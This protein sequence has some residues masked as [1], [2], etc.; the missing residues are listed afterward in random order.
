MDWSLYSVYFSRYFANSFLCLYTYAVILFIG[1]VLFKNKFTGESKNWLYVFNIII[2]YVSLFGLLYWIGELLIT[3]YGQNPYELHAFYTA[4]PAL[5]VW[6]IYYFLLFPSLMGLLFFNRKL[7]LR[8]WF[9]VFYVVVLNS[10][11]IWNWIQRFNNDYLPSEWSVITETFWEK[12]AK[13]ISV[14]VVII[15][16]YCLLYKRNKLP[17]SSI[18]FKNHVQSV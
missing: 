17:H 12:S 3:W 9:I 11:I 16:T 8:I 15:F 7:R 5:P 6:A 18:F 1:L 14:P 10:G 4:G 13:W 2:A